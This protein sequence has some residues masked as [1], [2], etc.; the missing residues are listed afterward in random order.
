MKLY[1][2][3]NI[4]NSIKK[5]TI[6]SKSFEVTLSH[7]YKQTIVQRLLAGLPYVIYTL[8]LQLTS[9]LAELGL[10]IQEAHAFSTIDGYSLDVFVVTGWH[11]GVQSCSLLHDIVAID[12]LLF[13]YSISS[14]MF[15]LLMI[16]SF[17]AI[18]RVP[19]SYK[20]SYFRNFTKLRY[21]FPSHS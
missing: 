18:S 5:L 12:Y 11:L 3:L 7:F 6:H 4:D 15:M 16:I 20:E 21:S 13:K 2:L 14:A 17:P 8:I 19:S 1:I 9:L 10:D